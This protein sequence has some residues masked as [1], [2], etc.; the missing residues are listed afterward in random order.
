MLKD[1][2]HLELAR[3]IPV[4]L[5]LAACHSD[6]SKH[7]PSASITSSA[8]VADSGF[9]VSED[10]GEKP[11]LAASISALEE[12]TFERWTFRQIS[13]GRIVGA[14]RRFTWGPRRSPFSALARL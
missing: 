5:C 2:S 12:A 11:A 8:N 6:G 10:A 14:P 7:E 13:V 1:P 3:A 9:P 4:W